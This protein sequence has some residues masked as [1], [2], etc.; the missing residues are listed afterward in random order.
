MVKEVNAAH[1]LVKG[2]EKAKMLADKVAAGEDFAKL[3][4]QYSECPSG[5]RGGQLG[6]FGRGKMVRE[7]EKVSF[8]N[9]VGKVVGPFKTD[10]GWHLLKVLGKR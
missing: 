9:E 1:I 5:K 7:F 6:W 3:A 2:M 10:F 8:E 4:K